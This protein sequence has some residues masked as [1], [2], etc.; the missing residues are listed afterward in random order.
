MKAMG[1]IIALVVV[2]TASPHAQATLTGKWRGTTN[3][4]A[5]LVLDLTA[6]EASLSGTLTRDG[7]TS[8]LADGKISKDTFTFS[9]QLN[10]RAEKFAGQVTG[11]EI[12][13]WLERQGPE[14]AIMLKRE[15][16]R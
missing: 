9:A 16:T 3:A 12:K 15:N 8:T 1:S 2:L 4:G 6:K 13:I 14:R 7:Q 10:D 11:D 5:E